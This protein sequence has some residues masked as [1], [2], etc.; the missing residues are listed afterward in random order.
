MVVSADAEDGS[1]RFAILLPNAIPWRQFYLPQAV[2]FTTLTE[3][4]TDKA[5][6]AQMMEW[7]RQH[8][9]LLTEA[10]LRAQL[11]E[12]GIADTA[13]DGYIE[14]A[15]Q[16]RNWSHDFSAAHITA[17][18]SRNEDGQVVVRKTDLVGSMPG[19]RVFVLRCDWCGHEYGANGCDVH[20]CLCPHCQDGPPGLPTSSVLG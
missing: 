7:F 17:I 20:R 18:G 10:E 15:R 19:Q 14:R 4:L 6:Q 9:S 5:A 16:M 13:A 3:R 8:V 11:A 2:K 1:E 12:I